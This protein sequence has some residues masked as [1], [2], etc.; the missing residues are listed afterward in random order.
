MQHTIWICCFFGMDRNFR[1]VHSD[2]LPAAVVRVEGSSAEMHGTMKIWETRSNP[3]GSNFS[4][5]NSG[6]ALRD[7]CSA[8]RSATSD[9]VM[10][11]MA[12]FFTK[13][14]DS[15]RFFEK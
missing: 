7:V 10:D 11:A 8:L 14:T 5:R 9:K 15:M 13:I 3:A 2:K 4:L 12:I 1:F 6:V